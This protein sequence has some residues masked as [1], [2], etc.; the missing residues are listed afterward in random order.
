[1]DGAKDVV[2]VRDSSPGDR[3]KMRMEGSK[4]MVHVRN[5]PP[6]DRWEEMPMEGG[7]GMVHVRICSPI[8]PWEAMGRGESQGTAYGAHVVHVTIWTWSAGECWKGRA[9]GG[10]QPAW[11]Q[12]VGQWMR[13]SLPTSWL[14][15][16][17]SGAGH[18][19]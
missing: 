1:M 7:K 15:L 18:G 6:G 4:G 14:L 11:K 2:H 5:S 19:R 13:E 8:A 3:W 16:C 12:S 10:R 9:C 17:C